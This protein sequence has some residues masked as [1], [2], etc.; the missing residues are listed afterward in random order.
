MLDFN[1]MKK[2]GFV[3]SVGFVFYIL[4]LGDLFSEPAESPT[5]LLNSPFLDINPKVDE[6]KP[7]S[8]KEFTERKIKLGFKAIDYIGEFFDSKNIS[9]ISE[10]F[11]EIADWVR[12]ERKFEKWLEKKFNIDIDLSEDKGIIVYKFKW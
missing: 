5:S 1:G 11:Y 8:H 6:W 2:I 7:L 4:I 9:F 12:K 3:I 10:G